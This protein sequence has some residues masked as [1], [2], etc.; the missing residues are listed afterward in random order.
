MHLFKIRHKKIER[1]YIVG[2]TQLYVSDVETVL[3]ALP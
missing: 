3:C 2:S 1:Y